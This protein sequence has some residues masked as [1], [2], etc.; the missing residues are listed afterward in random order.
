MNGSIDC[1][2]PSMKMVPPSSVQ[3]YLIAAK[4][5]FL[6]LEALATNSGQT[7]MACAFL[8][9]QAL[10]CALKSYLS[11]A[12]KPETELK[13][14]SVRHNLE[15]LWTEAVCKGLCIQSDPPQWCVT[16]NSGHDKPYYFRYPMGLNGFV[17]PALVPMT[18]DLRSLLAKV[19]QIVS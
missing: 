19:E 15:W 17:F 14:P 1:T 11:H 4:G 18:S 16:L 13:I 9:A 7:T 3:S 10:E 12:G 6:G 2:L 5:L 8:A